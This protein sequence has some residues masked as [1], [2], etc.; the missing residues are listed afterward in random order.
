MRGNFADIF[1]YYYADMPAS[2][3]EA[4]GFYTYYHPDL[5]VQPYAP[6]Y[7]TLTRYI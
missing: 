7:H 3:I 4:W 5:R 6:N 2:P 1:I